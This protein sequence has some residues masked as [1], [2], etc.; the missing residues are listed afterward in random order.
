MDKEQSSKKRFSAIFVVIVFLFVLIPYVKVEILTWKYGQEFKNLYKQSAMMDQIAYLKVMY[1][2]ETRAQIYY[3]Q[4]EH[5]GASLYNL[6]KN[7]DKWELDSW[8]TVWSK[9]G[10]ADGFIWPYYR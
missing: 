10:S 4:G 9:H 7:N 3:V 8:S 1:Y 6:K 2:S 5:L